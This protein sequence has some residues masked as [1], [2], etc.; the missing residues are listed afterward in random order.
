MGSGHIWFRLWLKGPHINKTTTVRFRQTTDQGPII[1]HGRIVIKQ[2]IA[3]THV[4]II[5]DI[6][7]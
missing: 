6:L 3:I 5:A 4:V 1:S 7:H 2:Y